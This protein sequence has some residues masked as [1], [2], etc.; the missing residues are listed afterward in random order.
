MSIRA[1][2]V[3]EAPAAMVGDKPLT[4]VNPASKRRLDVVRFPVPVL[5]TVKVRTMPAAP[6]AMLPKSV[7]SAN[8]G[9][10]SPSAIFSPLPSTATSGVPALVLM[11]AALEALLSSFASTSVLLKSATVMI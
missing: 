4:S 2:N 11:A 10:M 8:P 1:W 3:S 7:K 6:C 9:I 5:L